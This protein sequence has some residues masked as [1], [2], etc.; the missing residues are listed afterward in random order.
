MTK[1]GHRGKMLTTEVRNSLLSLRSHD[2]FFLTEIQNTSPDTSPH[3]NCKVWSYCSS[4]NCSYSSC[5]IIKFCKSCEN[6]KTWV[7]NPVTYFWFKKK[8][9]FDNCRAKIPVIFRGIFFVVSQN[10]Y[11]FVQLFLVGPLTMLC[12]TLVGKHCRVV[13]NML[14]DVSNEFTA[15]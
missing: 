13:W 11:I 15:V 4:A 5:R 2:T 8:G 7:S 1:L 14:T 3:L 12:R 6:L 10:V 9:L